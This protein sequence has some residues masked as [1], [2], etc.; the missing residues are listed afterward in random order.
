MNEWLKPENWQ[1]GP[2]NAPGLW[3]VE[4]CKSIFGS[5]YEVHQIPVEGFELLNWHPSVRRSRRIE[6]PPDPL[7]PTLHEKCAEQIC[8]QTRNAFPHGYD[9]GQLK[10]VASIL[11]EHYGPLQA[12]LDQLRDVA[13]I[14]S[15]Q[16]EI[17]A[18]NCQLRE[19][20]L[21][22][23]RQ[24]VKELESAPTME[25]ALTQEMLE[26]L[27]RKPTVPEQSIP[28]KPAEPSSVPVKPRA[29]ECKDDGERCY[30]IECFDMRVVLRNNCS[31]SNW[32]KRTH[33]GEFER[34]SGEKFDQRYTDF[35]YLPDEPAVFR[36]RRNGRAEVYV[37]FQNGDKTWV[38]L[39]EN[40]LLTSSFE[41]QFTR[42]DREKMK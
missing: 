31:V 13:E 4:V 24:R 9:N 35:H 36:V 39:Y 11:S 28:E 7:P 14:R 6:L 22:Q 37:A 5:E 12:E 25:F 27:Q 40:W 41:D 16:I 30:G 3:V 18:E 19:Q 34:D 17:L 26:S 2:P 21:Y 15:K 38:S 42:I 23:L 29:F 1:D 10:Q 20:E 33:S 8:D 32:L